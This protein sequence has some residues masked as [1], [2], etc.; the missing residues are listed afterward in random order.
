MKNVNQ[1]GLN[2]LSQEE[3]KNIDGGDWRDTING[4]IDKA[5]DWLAEREVPLYIRHI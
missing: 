4:Y 2:E 3:L 5:N 1:E